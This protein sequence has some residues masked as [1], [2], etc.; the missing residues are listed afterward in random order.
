MIWQAAD[1]SGDYYFTNGLNGNRINPYQ[2]EIDEINYLINQYEILPSITN[3][4]Y[5]I[6]E[7][8]ELITRRHK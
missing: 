7:G 8:K 4:N 1:Q 5:T 6:V 3:Q 2:N